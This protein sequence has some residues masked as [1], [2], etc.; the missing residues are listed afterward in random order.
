M[1]SRINKDKTKNEYPRLMISDRFG[2]VVLFSGPSCG[3][4]LNSGSGVQS[5]GYVD[6]DWCMDVFAPFGDSV[7]LS[8]DKL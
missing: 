5:V 1:F 6:D 7:E 8:N 4:V 3:T 2:T